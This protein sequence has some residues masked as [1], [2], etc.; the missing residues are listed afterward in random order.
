VSA[1]LVSVD[2][3]K[4][5]SFAAAGIERPPNIDIQNDPGMVDHGGAFYSPFST[6]LE[7]ATARTDAALATPGRRQDV[8]QPTLDLVTA[9]ITAG[10][11][12][13]VVFVLAR[14]FIAT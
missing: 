11:A 12:A 3:E 4:E 14:L 2:A 1:S 5:P 13:G 6:A 9:A 8:K 7:S 10:A